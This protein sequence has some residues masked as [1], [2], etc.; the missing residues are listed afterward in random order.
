MSRTSTSRP[1]DTGSVDTIEVVDLQKSYGDVKAVRSVSFTVPRGTCTA[2][3]GPNGAGKTVTVEILEGYR[4][5]DAG[6]VSVLGVDPRQGGL[7]W[8]SRIGIVLQTSR[9]LSDLTVAEAVQHFAAYFPAPARSDDVIEI[10]G[11]QEKAASRIGRLSGGQRRRLDV[12]IGIVGRPEVLFLDEPTTGFDP[13]A[14]RSF[15]TLIEDLKMHGVTIVLTTHYLEEAEQ[16][17]DSVCV[18][19]NGRS[20]ASGTPTEIRALAG[21]STVVSWTGSAGEESERTTTPTSLVMELRERFGGEIPGLRVTRPNLET[22]YLDLLASDG[23][24]TT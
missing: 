4:R 24:R 3:L 7:D 16:L 2:L 15:W 20:I 12:A 8:R 1:P 10:V 19:S 22:S 23:N 14:R 9:D 21:D 13:E 6:H 5:A 17:A 11:L 18:I